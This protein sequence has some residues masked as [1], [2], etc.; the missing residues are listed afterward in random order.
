MTDQSHTYKIAMYQGFLLNWEKSHIQ[1]MLRQYYNVL[2]KLEEIEN[3]I[4]TN[5]TTIHKYENKLKNGE[6][7]LHRRVRIY[8]KENNINSKFQNSTPFD[9]TQIISRIISIIGGFYS[10]SYETIISIYKNEYNNTDN[11]IAF[12]PFIEI[13]KYK[14][15]NNKFIRLNNTIN[16]L[17]I[18]DEI[19][20]GND[21]YKIIKSNEFQVHLN[22]TNKEIYN[23]DSLTSI[24]FLYLF[25]KIKEYNSDPVINAFHKEIIERL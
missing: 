7:K 15:E 12:L 25:F 6:S 4:L 23:H 19:L 14:N 24:K 3:H 10:I 13:L 17:E 11:I 16:Q 2:L 22:E 8:A 9:S 1:K 5:K 20:I 21:I 18:I